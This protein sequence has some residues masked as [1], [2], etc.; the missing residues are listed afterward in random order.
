MVRGKMF[1]TLME[2]AVGMKLPDDARTRAL[3]LAGV[4]PFRA[5]SGGPFGRWFQFVLLLQEGVPSV[6][7]WLEAAFTHVASLPAPNKRGR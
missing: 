2:G 7:P 1:A 4:S 6:V 3:T 5:P